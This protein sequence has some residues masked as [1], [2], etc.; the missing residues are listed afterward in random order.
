MTAVIWGRE[1]NCVVD[2]CEQNSLEI[3]AKGFC[4]PKK[5]WDTQLKIRMKNYEITGKPDLVV[6]I[7]L[8]FTEQ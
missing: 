1:P 7:R 6:Q 2:V 5:D 4:S 3:Y 8:T